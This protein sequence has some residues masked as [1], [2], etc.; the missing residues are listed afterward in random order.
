MRPPIEGPQSWARFI[1]VR[2]RE[3]ILPTEFWNSIAVKVKVAVMTMAL[4]VAWT[5]RIRTARATNSQPG[6]KNSR[7]LE[8][9]T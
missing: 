2:V 7:N 9:E 6:E 5:I 4:P 3:K 8:N 1:A